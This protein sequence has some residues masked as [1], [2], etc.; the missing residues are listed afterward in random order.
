MATFVKIHAMK[1]FQK[2]SI[3]IFDIKGFLIS[4]I[5]AVMLRTRKKS[6]AKYQL[7]EKQYKPLCPAWTLYNGSD[8][9]H[10]LLSRHILL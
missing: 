5:N 10:C 4:V 9:A 6:C 1:C 7:K 8:G 2:K 3:E